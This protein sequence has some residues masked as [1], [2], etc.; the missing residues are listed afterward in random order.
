MLFPI[1]HC[2]MTRMLLEVGSYT[3]LSRAR[4]DQPRRKYLLPITADTQTLNGEAGQ[5]GRSKRGPTRHNHVCI[6][7]HRGFWCP[8]SPKSS[9]LPSRPLGRDTCSRIADSSWWFPS[10]RFGILGASLVAQ[11]LRICLPMQETW[12]RALVWE[13]PTCREA[14]RPV[15]HNY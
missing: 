5:R 10:L 14:T 9:H 7:S 11:W 15:S 4:L 6:K 3:S 12:V 8:H 13:D 2:V 1:Q